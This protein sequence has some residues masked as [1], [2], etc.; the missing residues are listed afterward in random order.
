MTVHGRSKNRLWQE[1]ERLRDTQSFSLRDIVASAQVNGPVHWRD[2]AALAPSERSVLSRPPYL[3]EFLARF[4][5]QVAPAA[6]LDP[7][8]SSPLPLAAVAEALPATQLVGLA[9]DPAVRDIGNAIAP[10]VD[11]RASDPLTALGS[12][13]ADD[14]DLILLS[15]PLGMRLPPELAVQPPQPPSREVADYV[16]LRSLQRVS[17]AG[18][19]LY[20]CTDGIFFKRGGQLLE[21]CA[22]VGFHLTGVVSVDRG[23]GPSTGI[24]SSLALFEREATSE[25]FVGRLDDRTSV[26]RLI[27][28]MLSRRTDP[29]NFHLGVLVERTYRGW[30][31]FVLQRELVEAFGA[32][33]LTALG[34]LGSVRS[35]SLRRQNDYEMPANAVLVPAVGAGEVLTYQPSHEGKNPLRLI[36][37]QLDPEKARAEYVAAILSSS[38][39]KRLR[40]STAT[41]STLPHIDAASLAEVRIPI[42]RLAAQAKAIAAASHLASMEA[43]VERLRSDL[44]RRPDQAK[45]VVERLESAARVDPVRRWLEA[46][47]YPLASVLQRYVALRDPEARVQSLIN[48]FE[49]TAQFGCAV[50]LSVFRADPNLFAE[51]Q[52]DLAKAAPPGR[53]LFDRADFGLWLG[54]GATL[55]RNARRL[56]GDKERQ[57]AFQAAIGPANVLVNQLS[58]KT[59]WALL[60]R[61][62]VVRNQRAHGGVV[63]REQLDQWLSGLEALLGDI[64]QAL[65]TSFEDVDLVLVEEGGYKNGVYTY[66]AAERLRG[67][68]AIF[69]Q[70]E[71]QTREPLESEHLTFV[72]RDTAISPVL[73]LV[74]LVRVGA[75]PG[76]VRN[77][78]Y[79]FESRKDGAVSYVSYH[80]EGEPRVKLHDH[81]LEELVR[82]IN[83]NQG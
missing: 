67:A 31:P 32:E 24:S 62:R 74:P 11:W 38:V 21:A 8:A 46:L 1:V 50:L 53:Q 80:F 68:N 40:E 22:A 82:E 29:A 76:N 49:A 55:A 12:P 25:L 56:A 43:T 72:G 3:L 26:P 51:V 9:A 23:F 60:D 64:E 5:Q 34:E 16:L 71:L 10:A 33:R 6:I 79:F 75:T 83:Q 36:E 7:F 28:N 59:L 15:P 61:A 63:S 45:R 13:E 41:G 27:D 42:P 78:C 47:P 66:R 44:W 58:N 18:R 35:L 39:G 52:S 57:E 19:V 2:V 17:P 4:A 37:V 70:F 14:F 20:H 65:G 77:A 48:F 81:D 54:M 73:K 69:E 30:R